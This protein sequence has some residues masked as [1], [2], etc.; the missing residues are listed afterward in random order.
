MFQSRI[1]IIKKRG[2]K[3][4]LLNKDASISDKIVIIML[5]VALFSFTYILSNAA[6]YRIENNLMLQID[7][8]KAVIKKLQDKVKEVR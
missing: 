6:C 4:M 3:K 1:K 8:Q 7:M 2:N 5:F